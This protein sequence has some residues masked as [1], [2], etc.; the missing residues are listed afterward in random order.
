MSKGIDKIAVRRSETARDMIKRLVVALRRFGLI[1]VAMNTKV[2]PI[3]AATITIINA[4]VRKMV[5]GEEKNRY[6]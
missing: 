4:I 6:P 1:H 2:L 5:K 3:I